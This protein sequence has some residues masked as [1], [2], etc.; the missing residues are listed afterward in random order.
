MFYFE[1]ARSLSSLNSEKASRA[2]FFFILLR[3]DRFKKI[4]YLH[5][6]PA[7]LFKFR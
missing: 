5:L 6:L 1:H 7:E 4:L 2:F 3:P